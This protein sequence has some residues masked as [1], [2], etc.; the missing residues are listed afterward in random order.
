MGELLNIFTRSTK[1]ETDSREDNNNNKDSE[2]SVEAEDEKTMNPGKENQATSETL[3]TISDDF[4][5]VMAFLQAVAVKY[6]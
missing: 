4:D 6:P 1:G 3:A 2:G 5:D